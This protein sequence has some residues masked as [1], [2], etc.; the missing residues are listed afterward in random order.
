MWRFS[1]RE[2][3]LVTTMFGLAMAVNVWNHRA[4]RHELQCSQRYADS[5]RGDWYDLRAVLTE[6]K[7]EL[8]RRDAQ[9]RA[10]HKS[11]ELQ[12]NPVTGH[13]C[14][15]V[16]EGPDWRILDR[17]VPAKPSRGLIPLP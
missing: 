16:Q 13:Y 15:N 2:V 8:Q 6:A 17:P 9:V 5:L 12:L 14:R 11:G 4:L 10:W 7:Q 3:I 1:L